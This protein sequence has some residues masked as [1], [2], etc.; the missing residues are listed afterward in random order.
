MNAN[1]ASSARKTRFDWRQ[2]LEASRDLSRTEIQSTGFVVGWF[3][4][5]RVRGDMPPG[6]ESA[7]RFWKEMVLGKSREPWQLEKWAEGMRGY[8]RWLDG[9]KRV[10]GDGRSIPERLETIMHSAGTRRRLDPALQHAAARGRTPAFPGETASSFFSAHRQ[11]E[12]P[13][14]VSQKR[15]GAGRTIQ[16]GEIQPRMNGNERGFRK[17]SGQFFGTEAIVRSRSRRAWLL[18]FHP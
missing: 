11:C 4:D 10:G 6:K 7:R 14:D 3:E 12:S 18:A 17:E 13:A 2:D 15:A 1:F 9:C 16:P 8:L 5:W